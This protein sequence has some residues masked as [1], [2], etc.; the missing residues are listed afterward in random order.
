[1]KNKLGA[2]GMMIVLAGAITL[3]PSAKADDWNQV[4]RCA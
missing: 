3:L 4:R 1:M 2:V